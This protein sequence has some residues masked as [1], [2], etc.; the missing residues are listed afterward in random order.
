[1]LASPLIPPE[2][3]LDAQASTAGMDISMPSSLKIPIFL[4]LALAAAALH[5]LFSRRR[6][7]SWARFFVYFACI[8][9]VV[10]GARM[11]FRWPLAP[12]GTRFHLEM[13]MALAGVVAYGALDLARR[14]PR[15]SQAVALGFLIMACVVQVRHYRHYARAISQAIDFTRTVEYEMAH[16]FAA[17]MNG[18][19]VFA[20]GTVSYWMNLYSDVPQFYGCCDQSVRNHEVMVA[21]YQI[22]SGNDG[23][24]A[25]PWLKAYGISAIGVAAT[26]SSQLGQP[27]GNPNK[28]EGVLPEAWRDGGSVVYRIPGANG[29]L[30]HVV[31]RS[32]TVRR[33]PVDG[34]DTGP[35][36]PLVDA[37]DRSGGAAGFRWL[38]SHEAEI[39]AQTGIDDVVFVQETYAPAWHATE[40]GRELKIVPDALGLMTIEPGSQGPHVIRMRYT[41]SREDVL[42]R[43]AQISGVLLLLFWVIW[44]AIQSRSRAGAKAFTEFKTVS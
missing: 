29:S 26:G 4:A 35:I 16:W 5:L 2:L 38:N 30:A 1:M 7:N 9:W 25:V 36:L 41:E 43:I 6:T 15:W 40:S 11:W 21:L 23:A 22:Y 39:T 32:A 27:F 8:S 44:S 28:F 12:I 42:A 14:L 10:V 17:N 20:P 19:R 31:N 24:V 18:Q 37:L 34:L 33:P 3:I 13:E